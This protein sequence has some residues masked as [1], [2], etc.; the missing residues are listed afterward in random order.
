[1]VDVT[2]TVLSLSFLLISLVVYKKI[3]PRLVT[4]LLSI[5]YFFAL[6]LIL[7]YWAAFSFTGEGIN[8]VI[9]FHLAYGLEG[10][11]FLEY[12][13]LILIVSAL[14]LINGL[15]LFKVMKSKKNQPTPKK[16]SK[17]KNLLLTSFFLLGSLALNPLIQDS[18]K[19][20]KN[21]KIFG[22]ETKEESLAAISSFKEYYK[23]PNLDINRTKDF[24]EINK[25]FVFIYAEGF[26]RTFFDES[27]FPGLIKG[28]REIEQRS[29]SFV[30]VRGVEG[31]GW[32]IGGI[33]ASQCGIPLLHGRNGVSGYDIFLPSAICLGDLLAEE[34]Y[35]LNYLGGA[36]L[37]F[38]GKGKFFKSHGFSNVFGKKELLPKQENKE[39]STSWGLYDDSLLDI[40]YERFIELSQQ[41]KKFGLFTLT[42]DTHHP[43]GHPSK[44]CEGNIYKDGSNPMLNAVT[45]SDYLISRFI[46][47][48][49]NSPYKDETIIVLVSDH[50]SM[51]NTAY[52]LLNKGERRNLFMIVDPSKDIRKKVKTVGSSLD[53]GTTVLS[54]LGYKTEIGL[55]RNLLNKNPELEKE[56]LFI[57]SKITEWRTPINAFWDFPKVM[58]SIQFNIEKKNLQIDNKEFKLPVIIELDKNLNTKI[59]PTEYDRRR[60][61]QNK[62]LL[63]VGECQ[64]VS[65]FILLTGRDEYCF[66]ARKGKDY[67]KIEKLDEN[68]TYTYTSDEIKKLFSF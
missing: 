2:F 23:T 7:G 5:I 53:I 13:K 10:A 8:E 3:F 42:L 14:L 64:N 38:A 6:F 52:N 28:L 15:I 34:G 30:N 4:I 58:D 48:I 67:V 1:M 39:Y 46:S 17:M 27:V 16:F 59:L 26:E 57:H 49:M 47:K 40:V 22:G 65:K 11:G 60:H 61:A 45:C 21:S 31:T 29:L 55:G 66:S 19:L 36:S 68:E 44:E 33:V 50:L 54:F 43:E 62:N 24:S 37:N 41:E 32:T 51:N 18:Y 20:Q 63:I 9:I 35:E 25:N 12:I 56:K